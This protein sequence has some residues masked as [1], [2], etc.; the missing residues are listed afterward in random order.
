MASDG[1]NKSYTHGAIYLDLG[2]LDPSKYIVYTNLS[3]NVVQTWITDSLGTQ[4]IRNLEKDLIQH[5]AL[6]YLHVLD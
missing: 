4:Q 3:Q 1:T 6:K 5:L 2:N